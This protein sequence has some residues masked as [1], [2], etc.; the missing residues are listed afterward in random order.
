MLAFPFTETGVTLWFDQHNIS[1][2]H[3]VIE[4]TIDEFGTEVP[5]LEII[6]AF[7][8]GPSDITDIISN[9]KL[10][11]EILESWLEKGLFQIDGVISELVELNWKKV[12]LVAYVIF[13]ED[14]CFDHFQEA[15]NC[16]G[17]DMISEVIF[18]ENCM[19]I[20]FETS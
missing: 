9:P 4:Q 14:A 15:V 18:L 12:V 6:R 3:E 17:Y 19:N 16:G 8:L 20:V 11:K 5:L 1:N 10:A 7:M 2:P 13:N